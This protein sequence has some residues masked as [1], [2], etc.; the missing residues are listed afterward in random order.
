M[1]RKKAVT[2]Q[3][4][5][6]VS[7]AREPG[8]EGVGEGPIFS[9]DLTSFDVLSA[10]L[11]EGAVTVIPA[12][13]LT[14]HAL[15]LP[16]R[17]A[18][19][20]AAALPFAI[21]DHLG[22]GLENTHVAQCGDAGAAG[23]M[24]AAAVSLE[25]MEDA[26]TQ[27]PGAPVFAE[28]FLIAR[29]DPSVD[30]TTRWVAL[31]QAGRVLVRASDGTGFAVRADMLPTLWHIAGEPAVESFGEAL[32]SGIVVRH[33]PDADPPL[34]D[35]AHLPDL[36]QG[37]FRPDLGLGKPL[38]WLAAA[39]VLGVVSHLCIAA[40]DARAQRGI[41]DDLQQVAQTALGPILP[42]ATADHSPELIQRQ[43]VA[44][45]QP[46]RGSDFVPLMNRVSTALASLPDPVQF[47][48]LNWSPD[49][50]RITI[51]APDLEAL[52][53]AEARLIDAGLRVSSGSATAEA[54]SARADLTVRP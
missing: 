44:L 1:N 12:E 17:S 30:E 15:T 14:L 3:D 35:P 39:C 22:Q 38:K 10:R 49:A 7:E 5:E 2:N 41:A 40:A 50:L 20:K 31:H 34:A 27:I 48:Q 18:R 47:R 52:Q 11:P 24:L 37:R 36:R 28:Q 46:Q 51:E 9:A 26:I 32:P 19:Q 8:S 43:L 42:G 25:V 45:K 54:G 16:M 33:Q 53:R 23:N 13:L 21:E 4:I 29:P 6:P